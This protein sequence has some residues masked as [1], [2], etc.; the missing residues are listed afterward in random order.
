MQS[1]SGNAIKAIKI[2]TVPKILILHLMRFSYGSR[3]VAKIHKPV[4]FSPELVLNYDLLV[5]PTLEMV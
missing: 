3:G 2:Q 5:Y 1:A 4:R